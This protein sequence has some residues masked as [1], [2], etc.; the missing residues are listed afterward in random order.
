MWKLKQEVKSRRKIEGKYLDLWLQNSSP[1]DKSNWNY[2]LFVPPSVLQKFLGL[3]Q[4]TSGRRDYPR[5]KGI[6]GLE[7]QNA[8]CR[9]CLV[10]L[11][12][13]HCLGLGKFAYALSIGGY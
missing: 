13:Q 10:Q 8:I 1:R 3:F 11:R 12:N 2:I 6:W 4:Q 7:L 9:L 5:T